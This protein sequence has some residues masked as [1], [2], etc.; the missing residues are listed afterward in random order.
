MSFNLDPSFDDDASAAQIQAAQAAAAH[1][2]AYEFNAVT[3]PVKTGFK[4]A[5]VTDNTGQTGGL[6]SN[7]TPAGAQT[8]SAPARKVAYYDQQGNAYNGPLYSTTGAGDGTQTFQVDPGYVGLT[9]QY[10]N[11]IGTNLFSTADRQKGQLIYSYDPTKYDSAGLAYLANIG[12]TGGWGSDTSSLANAVK[13]LG[14]DPQ[15]L[16]SSANAAGMDWSW[17]NPAS[18][19]AT[20]T[21][22]GYS[23]PGADKLKSTVGT[24]GFNNLINDYNTVE[25]NSWQAAHPRMSMTGMDYFTDIILPAL[26]AAAP[27]LGA[28]GEVGD[29]AGAASE[30]G[31]EGAEELGSSALGEGS[32]STIDAL[33]NAGTSLAKKA[34]LQALLN[35]GKVKA[36]PSSLFRSAGDVA[37]TFADGG[38]VDDFDFSDMG[39]FGDVGGF[40]PSSLIDP[41][42]LGDEAFAALSNA[43][44]GFGAIDP[45]QFA[46]P[47]GWTNGY[48]VASGMPD[49]ADPSAGAEAGQ[50]TGNMP[51]GGG[52]SDKTGSLLKSVGLVDKDGNI[53]WG[54]ALKSG[55]TLAGLAFNYANNKKL[56]TQGAQL[57]SAQIQPAKVFNIPGTALSGAPSFAINSPKNSNSEVKL[58]A[59]GGLAAHHAAMGQ[60]MPTVMLGMG[61]NRMPGAAAMQGGPRLYAEGGHT[62]PVHGAGGGQDDLVPARLSPGEYVFDAD[63]VAALGD[64]SSE[65]GARR[66]DAWREHLRQHKRSA[67]ANSIPPK[68]HDAPYYLKRR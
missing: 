25:N 55:A 14:L 45:S 19:L 5:G 6:P 36:D 47:S 38:L 11:D 39:D 54:K 42:S 27:V 53:D 48:D 56:A 21:Y 34:A 58:Y 29:A 40:D 50:G 41:S 10:G 30:A 7:T 35:K 66:L 51:S 18:V 37:S 1:K 32:G 68:A 23:G 65:E 67:P 62:G 52:S 2:A 3:D 15:Q 33:Q 20:A 8:A 17:S 16:I 64:G 24:D 26:S 57:S 43:P 59:R 13:N 12:N 49:T 31:S 46:T 61:L 9:G 44:D 22:G 4:Q 28:F 60:A 63:T